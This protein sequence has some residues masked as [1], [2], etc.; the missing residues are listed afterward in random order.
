[1]EDAA[2]LTSIELQAF[3]LFLLDSFVHRDDFRVGVL[4]LEVTYGNRA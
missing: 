1:M 2:R 4:L 3:L